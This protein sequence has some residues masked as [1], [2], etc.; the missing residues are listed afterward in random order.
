MKGEG[1]HIRLPGDKLWGDTQ[2]LEERGA[3]MGPQPVA[4]KHA[5]DTAAQ[6]KSCRN[7]LGAPEAVG[8]NKETSVKHPKGR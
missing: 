4:Q 8:A 3:S 6:L 1:E 7:E 5:G 2:W